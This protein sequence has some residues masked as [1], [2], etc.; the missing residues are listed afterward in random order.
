MTT[1]KHEVL[2]DELLG[3]TK[4]LSIYHDAIVQSLSLL[5]AFLFTT[6][7]RTHKSA[8]TSFFKSPWNLAKVF[9]LQF[10]VQPNHLWHCGSSWCG[11]AG[12][13]EVEVWQ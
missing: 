4:E 5:V 11:R 3:V 12:E 13:G 6:S 2:Q 1:A 8:H 9:H 10:T 7:T